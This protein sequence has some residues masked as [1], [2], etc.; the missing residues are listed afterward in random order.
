MNGS[1]VNGEPPHAGGPGDPVR[2][3]G[4]RLSVLKSGLA[5]LFGRSYWHQT[6]RPGRYFDPVRPA[7]YFRDYSAKADW[8]GE[9]D[10]H[11][12]IL[13]RD[14][15]G[16]PVTFPTAVI[17]KGLGHWERWIAS[18]RSDPRELDACLACARWLVS[19]QDK[20]GGW[21]VWNLIPRRSVSPYSGLTQGQ[22]IS[23]LVRGHVASG[24]EGF[25][26]SALEAFPLMVTLGA[27]GG[28]STRVPEGLIVEELPRVPVNPTLN[29]LVSG[30]FGLHDLAL[31]A[32]NSSI[33]E[34]SDACLAA[35]ISWLPRYD[36]GFWSY[37]RTDGTLA[38]PYYHKVHL[39][40]LAA[41]QRVDAHAPEIGEMSRR[42]AAQN[43]SL[44]CRTR[45][46]YVKAAQ[47]L[48]SPRPVG[49]R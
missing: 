21:P 28:V 9:V 8:S 7:G 5:A 18:E 49:I 23:L 34:A 45:A 2:A 10:A 16:R 17:Q 43:R 31:L 25:R 22:A 11:G 32:E 20:R 39:V 6:P 47:K 33:A 13:C 37:Y 3:M 19:A 12:I 29:G 4:Q 48:R 35:L 14:R 41:L 44:T 15:S 24:E 42:F 1:S 38:S 46:I 40:Q 27:D 36:A 30:Y 26:N